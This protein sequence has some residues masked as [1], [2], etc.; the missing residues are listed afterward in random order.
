LLNRPDVDPTRTFSN[1][2][3]E[4]RRVFGIEA[5]RIFLIREF[6]T[7]IEAEG[8]YINPRHVVLLVDF[9]TSLGRVYGI[10]SGGIS[11]QPIG[12]LAKASLDKAIDAFKEAGGFGENKAVV[13]TSASIY[14]GKKALIGTGYSEQFMDSS[15]FD[16]LEREL[17]EEADLKF[18]A[19]AFNNALSD[20]NELFSG[21]DAAYLEAAE[22][23]MFAD[24]KPDAIKEP[25]VAPTKI[26][27][28]PGPVSDQPLVKG[29]LVRSR[30]LDEASQK[31]NEAPCL[32]GPKPST[33]RVEAISSPLSVAGLPFAG[34]GKPKQLPTGVP[35]LPKEFDMTE[36]GLSAPGVPE[37]VLEEM[38][39][40]TISSPPMQAEAPLTV[41]PSP[42]FGLPQVPEEVPKEI[43]EKGSGVAVFD[44]EEFMK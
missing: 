4:I 37:A 17:N 18:D 11:R 15:K 5:A 1:N 12:A 36:F 27:S 8:N 44:L 2:V 6:I 33:I 35:P 31:L 9:M 22:E 16:Q 29:K 34:P 21:V 42:S 43:E 3:H 39:K 40:M 24:Y 13:G 10:T 7:V 26:I 30:A 19:I 38:Q 25:Q 28:S 32:R 20:T 14:V 23:E 41:L